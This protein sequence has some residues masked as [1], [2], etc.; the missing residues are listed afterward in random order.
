ML[1]EFFREP[2]GLWLKC[3]WWSWAS[4]KVLA[5]GKPW[6][7]GGEEGTVPVFRWPYLTPSTSFWVYSVASVVS[8]S[9][10]PHG[11]KPARR[12]CPWDFPSKNTGVGCHSLLQGIFL[13]QGS[14]PYL[15]CLLHWQVGSLLW[16]TREAHLLGSECFA[17][18]LMFILL[19]WLLCLYMLNGG[20]TVVNG[21]TWNNRDT[22]F[23]YLK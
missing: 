20:Q 22:F 19:S 2:S 13:T 7:G 3:P 15:L 16:T 17:L 8:Y 12:L 10:W 4:P 18:I 1:C 11:L 5:S 14:N 9:L 21:I 23:G 6:L